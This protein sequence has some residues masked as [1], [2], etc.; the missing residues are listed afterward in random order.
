LVLIGFLVWFSF[1]GA[2]PSPAAK[3]GEEVKEASPSSQSAPGPQAAAAASARDSAT[4]LR[5]QLE[6]VFSGIKEANQKKD[7]SQLLS[8]YSPNFAQ[9]TQRA[10]NISKTWK[11][12][13]YPK[14]EFEIHEIS[15]LV[16]NTAIA[17]VT[18]EVEAQNISTHKSKN[19]SKTYSIKFVQESG[20]WRIKSLDETR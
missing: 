17:R 5:S 2:P 4:I 14:M 12:Y 16:D 20:Q 19:I 8:Y 15:R 3:K 13:D 1:R 9:L 10:Q 7:L 18:W 11:I 6:Q